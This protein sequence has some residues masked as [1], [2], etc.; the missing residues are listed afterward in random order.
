MQGVGLAPTLPIVL[1]PSCPLPCTNREGE[2]KGKPYTLH[3]L[4]ERSYD[5]PTPPSPPVGAAALFC[6]SN[7]LGAIFGAAAH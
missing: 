5:P 3:E 6:V 7:S 4:E 1:C 2:D